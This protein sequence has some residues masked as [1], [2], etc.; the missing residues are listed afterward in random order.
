[1]PFVKVVFSP[2]ASDPK[3]EQKMVPQTLRSTDPFFAPLIRL[4]NEYKG[5]FI[6]LLV[7]DLLIGAPISRGALPHNMER[8][9]QP[10]KEALSM[11]RTG[12]SK[13]TPKE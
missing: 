12:L 3:M 13:A 2:A 1:M 7:G 8:P 5:D 10:S 9:I 4:H 6:M 11:V